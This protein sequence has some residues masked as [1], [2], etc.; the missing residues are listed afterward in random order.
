MVKENMKHFS[1][2]LLLIFGTFSLTQAQWEADVRLTNAPKES[3]FPYNPKRSITAIGDSVHIVWMDKRDGNYEIYYKRSVDGGLNW[4]P[5][6]RLTNDTLPSMDPTIEAVGSVV[7]VFWENGLYDKEEIYYKRS[8]DGGSTWGVDTRLTNSDGFS[9]Y[10]S[11]SISGSLIHLVWFDMRTGKYQVFYKCSTDGGT[12]WGTDTQLVNSSGMAA[13][14]MIVASGK[15]VNMVWYDNRDGNWEVYFKRS[16]D[17]GKSWA[18]DTRLTSNSGSSDFPVLAVSG[19]VIHVVWEDNRNGNYEVYYKRSTDG[20]INWG[21]DTRLTNDALV[22][23]YASIAAVGSVVH[24][25]WYDNRTG[26]YQIY[27]KQSTDGGLNWSNDI[28]LTT[29][30][31][32][33]TSPQMAVSGSAIHLVWDDWRHL[34]YEIYYKRNLT[35]KL[36]GVN[37]LDLTG[38]GIS[39]YPNPFSEYTNIEFASQDLENVSI[40]IFDQTGKL[41]QSLKCENLKSGKNTLQWNASDSN[42]LPVQGGCYY[43]KVNSGNKL[44]VKKMMVLR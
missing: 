1:I 40:E 23:D 21:A 42:N 43:L 38:S 6:I 11:A 7:H 24:I 30:N 28:R 16:S 32:V 41:I 27:Y 14:P 4:G 36:S 19:S 29:T 31:F 22:S 33:A 18:E 17:G 44:Y 3:H 34:D 26:E 13:S 9:G 12:N 35:G 5:D 37:D 15:S 2:V 8:T 25:V 20:G 10:S 39:V